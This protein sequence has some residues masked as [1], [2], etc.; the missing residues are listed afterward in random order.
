MKRKFYTV[1]KS[2]FK[3]K[4]KSVIIKGDK[5]KMNIFEG[6]IIFNKFKGRIASV[7]V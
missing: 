1:D 3:I 4:P 6:E 2:K 5:S 7:L